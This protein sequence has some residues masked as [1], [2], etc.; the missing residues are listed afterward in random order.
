MHDAGT[1]YG[2]RLVISVID[3]IVKS[4]P[5]RPWASIPLNDDDLSE[6]FRDL[7]FAQLA[8]AINAAAWWLHETIGKAPSGEFPTVAYLGPRDLR[9]PIIVMAAAKVGWKVLLPSLLTSME[10]K[11]HMARETKCKTFICGKALFSAV[12]TLQ[13]E[14]GGEKTLVVPEFEDLISTKGVLEYEYRKTWEEGKEDPLAIFHTSGS[15]GL[16]KLVTWTNDMYA[17]VDATRLLPDVDGIPSYTPTNALMGEGKRFW[18]ML[19]LFHSAG[20]LCALAGPVFS[21]FTAVVGPASKIPTPALADEMHRLANIDGGLYAPAL[22][23]DLIANPSYKANLLKLSN[24]IFSGAP[25]SKPS[26]DLLAQK[27]IV[28]PMIGSTE[29]AWWSTVPLDGK[30]DWRDWEYYRFHPSSGATFEPAHDDLYEL[31]AV[32]TPESHVTMNFWK[33]P[34]LKGITTFR[35]KDLFSPHPDPV[36]AEKG[37][38][39]YRGRTDDLIVLTGEVKMYVASAEE[40]LK[41]ANPLIKAAVAGGQGRKVPFLLLELR[42]IEEE[43]KNTNSEELGNLEDIWKTVEEVNKTILAQT[44]FRKELV[45]IAG[46]D[47]PFVRLPKGPVDRRQTLGLYEQEIE[48]MY[49]KA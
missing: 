39:R 22:L 18:V 43:N 46:N 45:L 14:V 42:A 37:L 6:G 33:V 4:T 9:Y 49:A 29:G 7:S 13:K 41:T 24:V 12:E 48:A 2:R 23:E 15:S 19:P 38:W 31:V 47:K 21:G 1:S 32:K 28:A 3:A 5:E 8:T 44:R 11:T 30:L 17:T 36:K 34:E 35:T 20:L 27:G 16:P 26:G 25:L 40:R 10:A